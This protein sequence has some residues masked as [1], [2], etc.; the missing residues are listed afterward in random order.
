MLYPKNR[1]PSLS[2]E[3]F[4]SPTEEYRG[5][6]FWAFNCRLE[7]E[8]LE[9][10]I[11]ILRDMGFG[12]FHMHVRTGLDT[13]YL[14][15]EFLEDIRFCV[16][17]AGENHMLAWLYD[18]DRWP[19]GAAGG[20]VTK[21]PAFRARYLRL[22]ASP[23]AG[24]EERTPSSTEDAA[25]P[26]LLA[27]YDVEL[28][29][30]GALSRYTQIL[31]EAPA[32]GVKWY[33]YLELQAP[34]PWYNNLTYV[35]TLDKKA[36]ERF[37][38]ITHEA[39][40]RLLGKEFGRRVPA[41]FTDEPQFTRKKPL[42]FAE[43]REDALLPFT[44]DL[45]DTFRKAYGEDL[46]AS[47]PE[48]FWELPKGRVS[49]I[50]YLYHDHIAE[51]FS[52]AFA[53]TIGSWC[54][55][56]GLALTG[57]MMEEPTL[58]SQT[59]AL[60]EAMRSY[61]S[62][63]I[64][65]IDMLCR[66]R[67]YTT[68]KQ[69]QSAV[70]QFG[71]EGMVSELYGVTG[72][73][74][75]FRTYM[76]LGDWQ[77]SLGVTVRVPHL[78]WMSMAGEAKRDYPASIFYQSPWYMKY[79]LVEDH[80]ARLHT[81]LTRGKPLVKVGVIHP[82]ESYWLHWGP[83]KETSAPRQELE[84]SFENVTRWLLFGGIDFDFISESLLPD[85][86]PEEAGNP[87]PVGEMAYDVLIL[88]G[89]ETLRSSTLKRLSSFA[90]KGGR[91]LFAGR[92][93]SLVDALPSGEPETLL[94]EKGCGLLPMS[95]AALLGALEEAGA[96]QVE[97]WKVSGDGAEEL[98]HQ[99]RQDGDVRWL[100]LAQAKAPYNPDIPRE[101]TWEIALEGRWRPVEYDTS[102]G[103]IR[104]H[105]YR[106]EGGKTRLSHTLYEYDSLLLR[107]E[108]L[109]G[110]EGQVLASSQKEEGHPAPRLRILPL[111]EE[112]TFSLSEK[113]V[114]LLDQAEYALDGESYRPREEILRLDAALRD[115]L[116]W[117]RRKKEVAQPWVLPAEK[118]RHTLRLRFRVECERELS[119]LLLAVE[120][121]EDLALRWNGYEIPMPHREERGWYVDPAI[122]TL[123]LPPARA[124][125]NL[126]E[127][128]M[129]FGLRSNPEWCYILGD[130]GVKVRGARSVLTRPP[131]TLAFGS[132]VP[133]GL[134]FYG[135]NI[136]YHIP[137]ELPRGAKGLRIAATHFRGALVAAFAR[138]AGCKEGKV[139]QAEEEI[140][141]MLPPYEGVLPLSPGRWELLLT[142][143]GNRFNSFGQVHLSDEK[144]DWLGADAWRSQGAAW[145]YEYQLKPMGLLSAPQL[146]VEMKD[147]DEP[148]REKSGE[149]P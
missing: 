87:F 58:H 64:P 67:E 1:E 145:S 76:L 80:F 99:I 126:L 72:W 51:R 8:T 78:C 103:E 45:P 74:C 77:A 108:P 26:R 124:G 105:P 15:P 149:T 28:N 109:S 132:V 19:S 2:E 39:Y 17:K 57:H 140:P 48:L 44:D 70:H 10:Q 110:E 119:G 139:T 95:A 141:L 83:E 79:S 130:F 106:V 61:R 65:G 59:A 101:N 54:E 13:P 24:L 43:S 121:P 122:E 6:P 27:T 142:V 4:R 63:Q 138:P 100:F 40:A 143:Y 136:T 33:A 88:P 34:G 133:Q 12:G 53:D 91:I 9:K 113:N 46:M 148:E 75:D 115:S 90:R 41:I 135:G 81:A 125:E 82:G 3:L 123:P 137:I 50:R 147:P 144:E 49:R 89:C 71:R 112:M 93:P 62:F 29:E 94:L 22:T 7:K 38:E 86:C 117:P 129:P 47:L 30:K 127:I 102:S 14:S 85:L 35:N 98:L 56:H 84:E 73:D 66:R 68:A 128:T 114:L 131:E 18:E 120:R 37:V 31:P 21:D 69:A 96:R 25:A 16:E 60:G 20:F 92:V 118:P 146:W 134:P 104:P 116:S 52:S 5:A 55:K 42:P 36:I 107:L 97:Y 111:P 32:R 11:R 23:P